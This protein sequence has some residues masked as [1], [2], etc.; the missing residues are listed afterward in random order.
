MSDDQDFNRRYHARTEAEIAEANTVRA[1]Y[2]AE[3]LDRLRG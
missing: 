2:Q 1:R 3:V